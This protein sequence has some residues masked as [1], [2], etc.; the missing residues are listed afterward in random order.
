MPDVGT[1]ATMQLQPRAASHGMPKRYELPDDDE[2]I[3]WPLIAVALAA[4]GAAALLL[5][6]VGEL[7]ARD[8]RSG[9]RGASV[10]SASATRASML[11]SSLWAGKKYERRATLR[12]DSGAGAPPLVVASAVMP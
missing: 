10:S 6:G 9:D 1:R 8:P 2:A 11:A 7:F 12:G 5:F 3:R 4:V